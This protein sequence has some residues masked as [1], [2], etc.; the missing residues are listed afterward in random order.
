MTESQQEYPDSQQEHPE[1]R[2][3]R[4]LASR[5]QRLGGALLDGLIGAAAMVPLMWMLG[6]F[7][8]L[9]E[10]MRGGSSGGLGLGLTVTLFGT[11]WVVFLLL[12]GYLLYNYGQTIGKRLVGTKI[13]DER[14]A[15]PGFGKLFLL[16][17]LLPGV[18]SNVPV[19]GG[20]FALVNVLMIFRENHRCLHD[21]F[22]STYVVEA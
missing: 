20:L 21:D 18:I 7:D 14:G 16:R 5:W 17:Y 13:V 12:H 3:T 22:A 10:A 8:R 6:V 19:L 11:G 1:P 4:Y 2:S 9:G 15:V